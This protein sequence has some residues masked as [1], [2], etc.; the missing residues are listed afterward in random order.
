MSRRLVIDHANFNEYVERIETNA[1][2]IHR[3]T[4]NVTLIC[5][6]DGSFIDVIQ[7]LNN[8]KNVANQILERLK[9]KR[10]T[11][12]WTCHIGKFNKK[13]GK[14]ELT[15]ITYENGSVKAEESVADSIFFDS[16]TPETKDIFFNKYAM[17]FYI[18]TTTEKTKILQEFFKEITELYDGLAGGIPII[19]KIDKN[20]FQWLLKPHAAHTQNFTGYSQKW[21]PER[22][23]TS[24][25]SV[26]AWSY[27]TWTDVLELT[28]EC[29]S[30]MICM[31]SAW[32]TGDIHNNSAGAGSC[33]FYMDLTLDDDAISV[34]Q[35]EIGNSNLPAGDYAY[36]V[37]SGNP[38][39]IVEKGMHTIKLRL[40]AGDITN[41]IAHVN[42]RRLIVLKGFYQGGAS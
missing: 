32:A 27:D 7:N 34:T 1:P 5:G 3:L 21:M 11:A 2:K 36:G 38:I 33:A 14:T 8:H 23:E 42:N 17:P 25:S 20:G 26:Y 12:F 37:Y 13:T 39:L 9:K 35:G 29:E 19:A 40:R 22:I 16:F 24:Q 15:N 31:V 6:G 18:S 30:K 41:A 4:K 28:F 10:L